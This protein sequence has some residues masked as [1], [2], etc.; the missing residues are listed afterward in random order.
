MLGFSDGTKD[1][2]YLMAN[3]SIFKAKEKLTSI[4]R[5]YNIEVIFFDGRGGPPARGGGKTHQFYASLGPTIENKEVQLTIQGQ[6]ISSKFGIV[7][8]AQYNL[9]QLISSGISNEF[10][11]SAKNSLTK[12]QRAIINDLSDLSYKAYSDFK[13]HP[14]FL[15]YLEKMST[16][17][18]YAK[19]NIG[20]RPSKRNSSSSKLNFSDLRAIPFVGS[21]SQL[22][23]NVPGFYG[24]G[25]ALQKYE[26]RGEFDKVI[27][28][29]NNSKFFKSLIDNSMMSMKK[30]FFELTRYM[31]KDEEFGE[32]WQLIH[33][34]FL[35]AKRLVL[36][37]AGLDE[38]MQNYPVSKASIEVRESIVLPLLTIQ[39]YGLKKVQEL[40]AMKKMDKEELEVYEKI[41]TRSL[42]GNINA[43]RNSA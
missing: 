29:Y 42:F 10:F 2:G 32:F 36:K 16:L 23:Q 43:S 26:D 1:G 25:Y 12:E 17:Q 22:K 20:S 13:Q 8:A 35:N 11:D 14:K 7:E 19:T 21:W 5:K 3:W 37:L 41:I 9:E 4:S 33:N 15:P 30:S 6:T 28:F 24:V 27:H 39:Q 38:L 18:Y 34:E 31:E 40:K